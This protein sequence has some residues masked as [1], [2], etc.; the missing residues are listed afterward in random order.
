MAGQPQQMWTGQEMRLSRWQCAR[1]QSCVPIYV[2]DTFKAY[3]NGYLHSTKRSNFSCHNEITGCLLL[4]SRN[5]G[6]EQEQ[7]VGSVSMAGTVV[8]LH[9]SS[10]FCLLH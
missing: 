7:P 8:T 5:G 6:A 2:W 10:L 3:G 1:Q 9:W 4:A